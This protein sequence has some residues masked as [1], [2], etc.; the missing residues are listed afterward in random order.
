MAVVA[1]VSMW[2]R[3]IPILAGRC[4]GFGGD[5]GLKG[6][7]FAARQLFFIRHTTNHTTLQESSLAVA[8]N[9]SVTKKVA[10]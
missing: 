5:T 7:F 9:F 4:G 6:N 3:T 10:K 8:P 1:F 2:M